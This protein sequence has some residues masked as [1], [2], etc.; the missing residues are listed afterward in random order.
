MFVPVFSDGDNIIL[1][2]CPPPILSWQFHFIL[3][4]NHRIFLIKN[5]MVHNMN[6][7]GLLYFRLRFLIYFLINELIKKYLNV[8]VDRSKFFA[9]R[10]AL[11]SCTSSYDYS[12]FFPRTHTHTHRHSHHNDVSQGHFM[13]QR[14]WHPNKFRLIF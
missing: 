14:S 11:C 10:A 1:S 4:R 12:I 13:V 9:S 2:V 3:S 7:F 6:A 8:S 5:I